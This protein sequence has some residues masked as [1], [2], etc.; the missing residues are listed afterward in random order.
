MTGLVERIMTLD[1]R[2]HKNSLPK[3]EPISMI[4]LVMTPLQCSGQVTR[5]HN[6]TYTGTHL[7]QLQ[8]L[9]SVQSSYQATS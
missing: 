8:R 2:T 6:N 9:N 7:Q 3:Y 1:W 5:N 4:I